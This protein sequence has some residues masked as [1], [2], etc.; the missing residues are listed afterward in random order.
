M[1]RRQAAGL[2]APVLAI[3]FFFPGCATVTRSS[4]QTVPVTSS[5]PGARVLVN[6]V[7]AGVTP[8]DLRLP[9][10]EKIQVIRIES[11]GYNPLEV[12]V[13]RGLSTPHAMANVLLGGIIGYT[14]AVASY[15]ANDETAN[16]G[17]LL[18]IWIPASIGGLFL[19]DMVTNA[20]YTLRPY[21]LIVTLSKADATPRV[22]TVFV[23]AGDLS[24]VKWI[25]VRRD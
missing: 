14:A 24:N 3:A 25:R 21:D 12:R 5:P 18:A 20:G 9:R 8:L 15:L 17:T 2:L 23:D 7:Q 16:G 22:D 1:W 4:R 13:R 19:I 11:P 10:A 6:G